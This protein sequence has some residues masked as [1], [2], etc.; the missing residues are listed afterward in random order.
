MRRVLSTYI[1]RHGNP[2]AIYAIQGSVMR[3]KEVE[4]GA[5]YEIV[6][7]LGLGDNY[8]KAELTEVTDDYRTLFFRNPENPIKRIGI[9]IMNI[10]KYV[11]K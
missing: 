1:S 4:I 3:N 7:R 5:T 6:Y 2:V 10:L 11:K 8:L 9:P